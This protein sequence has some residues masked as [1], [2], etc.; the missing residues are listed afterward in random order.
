MNEDFY[1]N[2]Y[3]SQTLTDAINGKDIRIYKM[4]KWLFKK[5]DLLGTHRFCLEKQTAKKNLYASLSNTSFL[6]I[7]DGLAYITLILLV[8]QNKIDI[9][10]FTFMI[11]IVTSFSAWLNGFISSSNAL[12]QENIKVNNYRAFL[13]DVVNVDNKNIHSIKDLKKPY[14]IEFQN[15]SF[16]YPDTDIEIIHN[17]SFKI[18]AL[19]KVAIVGFNGAGKTT[20]IKLLC[21]LYHP[22][23][24][25]ILINNIDIN[26]F[27]IADYMDVISAVFQDSNP[28]AFTIL[29]NVTCETPREDG[30]KAI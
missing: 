26:S 13:D 18:D 8:T 6:F 21:G 25:K 4:Q 20:L 12:R 29:Q 7:R 14:T 10:T 3:L 23:S 27:N 16:V 15:V 9:P 1:E 28:I 17:I 2:E 24:G 5:Y 19:E 22:T 30:Q 11:G